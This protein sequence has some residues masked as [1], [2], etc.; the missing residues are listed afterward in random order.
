VFVSVTEAV[1]ADLDAIAWLAE[2][3]YREE[4]FD[5]TTDELRANAA[6]LIG[7]PTALVLVAR[8]DGAPVGFAITTT[9]FGLEHGLIAELE[10]LY[11]LPEAR[12]RG[13]A[14]RLI[15]RSRTWA[16][17]AGCAELEVV[18]DPAGDARHGLRDFYTAL[19]FEDLGRRLLSQ[20]L[21]G[22]S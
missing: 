16:E 6:A 20:P 21:I 3:F 1:A 5:T 17:A 10:D 2:R 18:I 11:V 19:G 15:D 7:S 4:G 14:R 13:A 9:S 22:P 8:T 12:R